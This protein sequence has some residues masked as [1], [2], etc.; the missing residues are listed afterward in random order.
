MTDHLNRR[1]FIKAAGAAGALLIGN[2]SFA[3]ATKPPMGRVVVIG[4]GYAGATAAKYLRMWSLG[5]IE[6]IVV[7]PNKQFVSCPLSNLV[8]GGSKS[9]ND[10]TF[11]YDALKANHGIKWVQDTV[12]AID[13]TAKKVTM[14]RGE[15][16]YDRLVVAPGVDFIYDG[17]PMLASAEAQSQIPHA[18]KAGWQTVNLRKQLE[19]MPDGGVFV[20]TIPKAP[21][22]CPPGPYERVCQ[23]ASYFKAHKPKSKIIVLDANAEIISKKGLFAKVFNETYAGIVDY[24]P[25]NVITG[26]DVATKT[27]TTDFDKIKAEVLNVIPPQRAGKIA[28]IANLTESDYPWCDVNFLTYE[29]KLVPSVH[30]LG[31]SV[32]AGLPKSAHMASNQAKVCANAI[33]QLMAGQAPDPAPVFANTCYS[34]V[35]AKSAMHVANVYRYDEGKKIMVSAE[36]GGVSMSPSEKEGEY[37]AAW[38]QNIWADTLT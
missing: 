29:S 18:W 11:G 23:V 20:M 16:S 33:V 25:D 31:D 34:Y 17:L 36:G 26:V 1:D 35:T 19:A 4:G 10:L 27:I 2:N 38:A 30:V 9:I 13:S 37:A 24:R 15:L 8:L 32:A 14:L 6:V 12:T 21:Y 5:A 22:R 3:R 7:E 28:Q